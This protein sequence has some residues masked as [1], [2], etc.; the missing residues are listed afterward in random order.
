[1]E[2]G[3]SEIGLNLINQGPGS[4]LNPGWNDSLSDDSMKYDF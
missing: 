1:M 3:E 4:L 2:D